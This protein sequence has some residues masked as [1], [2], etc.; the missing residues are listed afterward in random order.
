M[1]NE[2]LTHTTQTSFEWSLRETYIKNLIY[3]QQEKSYE[4]NIPTLF[5]QPFIAHSLY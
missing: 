1:T 2:R 4:N 5:L 3:S